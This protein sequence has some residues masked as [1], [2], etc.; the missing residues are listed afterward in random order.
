MLDINDYRGIRESYFKQ[1]RSYL[2]LTLNNSGFTLLL[3]AAV[4]QRTELVKLILQCKGLFPEVLAQR[5][6][7]GNTALHLAMYGDD[8]EL[9]RILLDADANIEAKNNVKVCLNN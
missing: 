6:K 4:E 9:I 5:D 3:L 2:S 1:G 8:L 7:F